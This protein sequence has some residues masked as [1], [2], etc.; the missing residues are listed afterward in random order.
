[1]SELRTVFISY[2]GGVVFVVIILSLQTT[3]YSTFPTKV[4]TPWYRIQGLNYLPQTTC[5]ASPPT[6]TC[7]AP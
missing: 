5:S 7:L 3:D 2:S 4:N 1:M 6:T